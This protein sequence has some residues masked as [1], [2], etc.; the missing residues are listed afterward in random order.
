[1]CGKTGIFAG[2]PRVAEWYV[3]PNTNIVLRLFIFG[4]SHITAKLRVRQSLSLHLTGRALPSQLHLAEY[5]PYLLY[6]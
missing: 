5:T 2:F 1:M 3:I 4:F 6:F